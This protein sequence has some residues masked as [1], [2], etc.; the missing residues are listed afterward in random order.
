VARVTSEEEYAYR[1]VIVTE[2]NNKPHPYSPNLPFE[3]G[4]KEVH[5]FGPHTTLR[6]ARQIKTRELKYGYRDNLYDITDAYV[7][8]ATNWHRVLDSDKV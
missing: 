4:I 7:E 6:Q 3:P 8:R 1:V 5:Y 2:R